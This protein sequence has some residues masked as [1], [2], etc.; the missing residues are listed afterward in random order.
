M[1]TPT[2]PEQARELA[3]WSKVPIKACDALRSLAQQVE[4]LTTEIKQRQA[5]WFATLTECEALTKERDE[6]KSKHFAFKDRDDMRNDAELYRH[7]RDN[8]AKNSENARE[9]FARLEPL[10]G[11]EFDAVV[12]ASIDAMG[13]AA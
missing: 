1:T 8:F 11:A 6:W 12:R 3:N 2:T 7:L 10:T 4:D 13:V 5:H 9:E